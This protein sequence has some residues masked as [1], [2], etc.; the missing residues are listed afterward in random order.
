M[1]MLADAR[2]E[3]VSLYPDPGRRGTLFRCFD[4]D[5]QRGFTPNWGMLILVFPAAAAL[6]LAVGMFIAA[7]FAG[8]V[9]SEKVLNY[10]KKILGVSK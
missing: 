3:F 5:P 1:E 8:S 2:G 4:Y 9:A 7:R 10:L 6:T